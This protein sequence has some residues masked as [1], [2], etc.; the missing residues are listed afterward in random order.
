MGSWRS[1]V[2]E[3]RGNHYTGTPSGP[4]VAEAR[5]KGA[6]EAKRIGPYDQQQHLI[7][8]MKNGGRR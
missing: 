5:R 2:W 4:A 7:G 6:R 3:S 1:I 8:N